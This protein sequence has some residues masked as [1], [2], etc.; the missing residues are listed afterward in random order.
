[1]LSEIKDYIISLVK[2]S[3]RNSVQ[4]CC[5]TYFKNKTHKFIYVKVSKQ[6]YLKSFVNQNAINSIKHLSTGQ[7]MNTFL[8]YIQ[9]TSQLSGNF[10]KE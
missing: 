1:M 4:I 8:N 5:W 3:L 6:L 2:C 10:E 7:H 9:G